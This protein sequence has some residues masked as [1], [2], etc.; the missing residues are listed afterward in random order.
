MDQVQDNEFNNTGQAEVSD[1]LEQLGSFN[2]NPSLFLLNLLAAQCFLGNVDKGAVFCCNKEGRVDVLAVLPQLEKG[3]T[4]PSWLTETAGLL[5]KE[6]A[7]DSVVIK[8]LERPSIDG[9]SSKGHIVIIPLKMAEIGNATSV[10]YI[11][12]DDAI[13]LEEKSQKLQVATRMLNYSEDRCAKLTGSERLKRLQQAMEI[14]S[15]INEHDKFTSTAMTFCNEVASQWQCQRVSLGFL[16]GRYVKLKAMSHTEDFSRKMKVVQDV[17]FAMEECLD[18]DI[19]VLSPASDESTYI[20][21][22][23]DELS[24]KHRSQAVLS[25]PLRQKGEVIAV[26]TLE[27]PADKIFNSDE[28]EII[29]LTCEL[30]TARLKNLYE[31]NRWIGATIA[32][33]TR[34]F[35]A[36]FLGPKHTWLKILTILC[37]AAILFIVFVKGEFRPKAPFILEAIQQQVIPA[38]FDGYIKSVAVEVGESIKGDDSILATLDTAELRL[39]LAAA[40]AEKAGYLKEFSAAMHDKETA[41]AQIAQANADKTQSQINLLNY[42]INQASLLSPISGIVVKGDLKRQ[43]GAPVKT[44]DILFEVCPLESLRAQLMVPEDLIFDIEVGQK[45]R[46][47]TASYPG[48]PIEFVVEVIN[49]MAEVINQ[50]NV[51]KV[52]VRLL[53]TYPWMRPGMEGV[54]K[55]SAG[56]RRYIWIW[57]RKIANWFRMKLWL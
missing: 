33:K 13:I 34:N 44:G 48:Q 41:Q 29:R 25:L 5:H 53:E 54:A 4:P 20:C 18:Q 46:L 43:I 31:Y 21:L 45:G 16:E 11:E 8:Q 38:P 9:Q 32:I 15:A 30:C 47:A 3:V 23:A 57:T 6:Q 42:K 26:L 51:F 52:R 40:K 55:V 56:K 28:I 19:E 27:R 50:R 14:L 22:A 24:Q 7:S 36:E 49:P 1:L 37:F 2:E 10:F 35:F 12:T 39:Q 17:E